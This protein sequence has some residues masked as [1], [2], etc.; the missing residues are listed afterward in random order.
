MVEKR[1]KDKFCFHILLYQ[2]NN[3]TDLLPKIWNYK[4]LYKL[5]NFK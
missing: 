2:P 5:N 4:P 3:V 1:N